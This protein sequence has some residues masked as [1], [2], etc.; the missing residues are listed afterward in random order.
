MKKLISKKCIY[1]LLIVSALFQPDHLRLA[2]GGGVTI[3]QSS[4]V[5]VKDNN[6]KEVF[7][8][9]KDGLRGGAVDLQ[10]GYVF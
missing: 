10:V 8:G 5:V 6:E 4:E 3:A 9:N 7:R 1:S 2:V